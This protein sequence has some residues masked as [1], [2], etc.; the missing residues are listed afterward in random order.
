LGAR[1]DLGR[2]LLVVYIFIYLNWFYAARR[3]PV[4]VRNLRLDPEGNQVIDIGQYSARLGKPLA[5]VLAVLLAQSAST[6][7]QT[8][9][10]WLHHSTFGEI[11]PI[12]GRD[13]SFYFFVL[14]SGST[15]AGWPFGRWSDA[16]ADLCSGLGPR[17]VGH[18]TP[19]PGGRRAAARPAHAAGDAAAVVAGRASLPAH[20]Q[21]RLLHSR[22]YPGASYTD[23]EVVIP[24]TWTLIMTYAAGALVL[25]LNFF[26][27]RRF[28]VPAT[29]I[30]CFGVQFL[31]IDVLPQLVQ[32]FIVAP[33]ELVKE[34]PYIE[35]NIAAT[36]KAFGVDNVQERDLTGEG[37][38]TVKD[39]E[40]N[41]ATFHSI[42]LWT[43]ARCSTR[44]P[45]SRKSVPTTISY[46]WTT[47][48]TRSTG[49][50]GR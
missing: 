47:I 32:K 37:Q 7:Y 5:I 20:P 4:V 46:R 21:P 2:I 16:G 40:N 15:C 28:L 45:R 23:I 19:R 41:A 12:L 44:S 33:N 42:R 31:G 11:D 27:K 17:R 26:R 49:S 43:T 8:L 1:F 30:V 14:H 25:A 38:L 29:V 22:A 13:L 36:R 3:L 10:A 24:A 34:S 50:H 9:L 39:I 18:D 35:R 6:E 48:A